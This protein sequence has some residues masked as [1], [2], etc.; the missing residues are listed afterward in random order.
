MWGVKCEVRNVECECILECGMRSSGTCGVWGV[1]CGKF[2]VQCGVWSGKQYWEVPR[3]SFVVECSIPVQ[4]A[5]FVV[6][7]SAGDCSVQDLLY[8]VVL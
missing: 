4:C 2:C 6:E 1:M 8:Q 3:A 7:S 5:R